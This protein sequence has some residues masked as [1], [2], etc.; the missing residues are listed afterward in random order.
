MSPDLVKIFALLISLVG[1]ASKDANINLPDKLILKQGDQIVAIGDSITAEGGYLKDTDA[2]LAAAYPDLKLP[3]II[4]VG[5]G[6]QKAEDLITRFQKDVIDRKPAVVTLSIGINDVWHRLGEPHD[7]KVLAAYKK[8]VAKMVDMAQKAGVKVILLTPTLIQEDPASEGNKRLPMYVSAEKEIA[9]DKNC[10]LVDL[11]QMF[12]DAL[13]KRPEGGA[14]ANGHWLTR[15]GVHM[16][17]PGDA[18]MSLGVLRGLGVPDAK[19][20][21]G[22]EKK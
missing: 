13:A 14:D 7:E 17:P 6:G 21:A 2:A 9:K 22:A 10:T 12:L 3:G 16:K 8:N 20:T 11:H 5:I 18:L 4:N 19:L 15:D 1:P